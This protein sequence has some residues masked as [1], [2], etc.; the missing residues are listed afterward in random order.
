M[1]ENAPFCTENF[2][3]FLRPAARTMQVLFLYPPPTFQMKVT[4][5]L[6]AYT[7]KKN[8]S[9]AAWG[10]SWED[11]VLR[12]WCGGTFNNRGITNCSQS[13]AVK[14]F[15]IGQYLAKIWTMTKWDVFHT[16]L[17]GLGKQLLPLL[18]YW[19]LLP[20]ETFTT[21]LAFSSPFCFRVKSPCR[22]DKRT[23]GRDP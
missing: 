20:C 17:S 7:H 5:L 11:K 10:M 9:T 13:G 6:T 15:E 3:N 4:P 21:I 1:T 18:C 23:D 8:P 16:T 22:I 14:N 19:V 2:K 12:L